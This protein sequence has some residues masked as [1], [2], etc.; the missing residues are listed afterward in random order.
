MNGTNHRP[1][2]S[3]TRTPP[4]RRLD[5]WQRSVEAELT[6]AERKYMRGLIEKMTDEQVDRVTQANP[7]EAA[8]ELRSEILRTRAIR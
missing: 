3:G 6:P 7:H 5:Q 2:G 8:L 4:E 1:Y